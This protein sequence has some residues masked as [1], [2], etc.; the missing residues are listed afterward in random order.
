MKKL[1]LILIFS[2]FLLVLLSCGMKIRKEDNKYIPYKGNEILVFQSNKNELDTIFLT[3]ISKFNACYDPLSLFKPACEGKELSCKKSD[4][5]Y[6]RY[7]P[8]QSLMSISKIKNE[9]YI[10]FDITLRYSWFYENAYMN[11]IDFKS[12]P[13][14]EMKI[15]DKIFNDV[16][17]IEAN[18]KYIERDNYVER[19][20]WSVSQGF[21][22]LD[23]RNRNWRLLKIIN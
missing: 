13:N 3:G 23:Q 1:K 15:G 5:N 6:D 8:Y 11:L 12:L 16:K 18:N 2:I 4:P 7:L 21:L 22:G 17:I 20:Y 14:S 19:F 10:G 9:T